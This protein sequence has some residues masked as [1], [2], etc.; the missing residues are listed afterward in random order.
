MADNIAGETSSG[1]GEVSGGGMPCS[2]SGGVAHA[3]K[4]TV[5]VYTMHLHKVYVHNL[6][7]ARA[8]TIKPGFCIISSRVR[9]LTHT[10]TSAHCP[11]KLLG[12]CFY[13][14]FL[15]F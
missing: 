13:F 5:R 1:L 2:K 8:Y 11:K 7:A 10:H 14:S 6:R 9:A 4:S 12:S 3:D 15:L